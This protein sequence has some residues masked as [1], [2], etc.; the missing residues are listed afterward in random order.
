MRYLSVCS[1]IEAVSVA[2]LPMGWEP[3]MFAEI[4]P[5]CAWLLHSRYRASR[6]VFMPSP[7]GAPTRKE[8]KQRNGA[9]MLLTLILD[10]NGKGRNKYIDPLTAE[11]VSTGLADHFVICEKHFD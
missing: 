5:F 3:V 1:G 7:R 6:P 11:P 10:G 2:W 8:A 9:K 4:D